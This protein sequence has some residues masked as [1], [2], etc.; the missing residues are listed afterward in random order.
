MVTIEE[1]AW[2]QVVQGLVGADGVVR[3][4]P[5]EVVGAELG[6]G[7]THGE[8][9][10]EL[11][12]VGAIGTFDGAIELGAARWQDEEPQAVLLTGDFER[13]HELTAAIDLD[14]ADGERH[15]GEDGIERLGRRPRGCPVVE[16]E[17]I[18]ATNDVVG[19]ELL[20]DFPGEWPDVDGVELHQIAWE[21]D[22]IAGWFP[23]GMEPPCEALARR[24]VPA[25][26]GVGQPAPFRLRGILD[27]LKRGGEVPA[28]PRRYIS[29]RK[30]L[31]RRLHAVRKPPGYRV[32]FPGD[33]VQL[34]TVDVRPLPGK[35]LKQFT[36]HDVISRWNVL[37]LHDRATAGTAAQALD[38]VLARMPFP[39]RA[40]QIDG[41]SEFMGAFEVACQQHGLRLFVL[42]P[43]S[44]KLNGAVERA[45]RTHTEEF[46]EC[47][48]MRRTVAELRP[49]HLTWERT[50]NTI[51]P[52]QALHY[53]TPRQFLD[54]YHSDRLRKEEVSPR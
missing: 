34:D 19:S 50:Y 20:Q 23:D 41:G 9:F 13:A 33:L 3:A 35:V 26:R 22:A 5:G 29:A 10:E 52:H 49:H 43:R 44:P 54:R 45:N 47:F 24:D 12:G 28:P 30:R 39:V 8:A 38:A 37:D 46:F 32:L 21:Q 25:W 4:L 48:P 2:G 40:I 27:Y 1:L 16:V 6:D 15:S 31:A 53:L 11:L 17:H 36:A 51:R 18:P 7:A 14:G 42:P